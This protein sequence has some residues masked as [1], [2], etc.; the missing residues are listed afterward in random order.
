[1]ITK[2]FI[3]TLTAR[4]LGPAG[5][6]K[7]GQGARIRAPRKIDGSQ[8][9]SIGDGTHILPHGWLCCLDKWRD[10]AFS[11]NMR[12]GDNVYIG[13]YCCITCISEIIIDDGC[14]LSEHVYITDC[15]HGLDP[16]CGP[17]LDQPLSSKGSV[18][19]GK[20][21][22]L[23]YRAVIMP[24]VSLGDYCVVGANS[25]VTRSFP[26]YSMVAG[27]PARMIKQYSLSG[28]KWLEPKTGYDQHSR[29]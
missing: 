6:G 21:C 22:F 5:I 18:H 15:S 3:K 23:G 26:A 7:I 11:P 14:V 28:R 10:S 24:G 9:I 27:S 20:Q 16:A 17:I 12:I 19:L 8:F 4:L 29:Q 25:V 13:H 1:M 2:A